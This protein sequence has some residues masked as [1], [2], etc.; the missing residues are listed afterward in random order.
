MVR[1]AAAHYMVVF[2]LLLFIFFLF[3]TFIPLLDDDSLFNLS[4]PVLRR[5]AEDELGI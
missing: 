4:L 5:I 1:Q 3:K 2:L